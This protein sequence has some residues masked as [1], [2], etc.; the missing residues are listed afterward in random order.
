MRAWQIRKFGP[1]DQV[2]ELVDLPVPNP[3]DG[4][5]LVEVRAVSLN[6]FDY[7]MIKGAP[8]IKTLAN[9]KLPLIPGIDF[10]GVVTKVSSSAGKVK[11][12]DEVFCKMPETGGAF[13][14]LV[15]AKTA[16]LAPKPK[17][18]TH[19]E[20]ASFPLVALTSWQSLVDVGNLSMGQKVFIPGGSGGIGTFAIQLA[21]TLGAEIATTTSAANTDLV[22]SLGAD[23][24]IDYKSRDFREVLSGYDVVYDTLG[25]KT[26]EQSLYVLKPGGLVVTINGVPDDEFVRARGM[27]WYFKP[28]LYLMGRKV[29]NLCREFGLRYKFVLAQ[30]DG[31][32]LSEISSLIDQGRIKPVID[33]IVPFEQLP[34]AFTYLK[35]GHAKG[36]VVATLRKE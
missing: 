29:R 14:E 1:V 16:W 19:E 3:R 25:G 15:V 11:V 21:R 28:I 18:L 22:K 4:E 7:K 36:K 5:V 34:Q 23:V 27:K 31:A 6:P 32:E 8:E 30:S 35:Q 33:R 13:A 9:L 2:L 26:L 24:V 10:S 12:G 17:T 20:A